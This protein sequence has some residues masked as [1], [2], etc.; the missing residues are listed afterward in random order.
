MQEMVYKNTRSKPKIIL[1]KGF[2][3]NYQ[4]I[5]LNLHTHPCAYIC[6]NKND[7]FFKKHY[8]KI[9]V[10]CHGGL[11]FSED[12]IIRILEYSDKYKCDTV[13]RFNRDWIIGWDYAHY[14]DYVAY[15][16]MNYD[17]KKWTTA[18]IKKECEYVINQLIELNFIET[19]IRE[20]EEW[21]GYFAESYLTQTDVDNE[22]EEALFDFVMCNVYVNG[23]TI[24][25]LDDDEF[26]EWKTLFDKID[27]RKIWDC[28][29]EILHPY[30]PFREHC[31]ADFYG[32]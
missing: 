20:Y 7:V 30:D 32:V 22:D 11:T 19:I 16:P 1:D 10:E 14:G 8:D 27:K 5:I 24:E 12:H 28:A 15:L 21:C 25:E 23:K 9:P 31:D 26:E 13:Q 18:E 2:Y 6:L 3:K 4:Y 17:D 29:D